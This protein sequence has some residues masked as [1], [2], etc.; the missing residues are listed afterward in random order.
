[1]IEL[2]KFVLNVNFIIGAILGGLV[3]HFVVPFIWK[4]KK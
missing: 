4:P 3:G 1:M 2:I